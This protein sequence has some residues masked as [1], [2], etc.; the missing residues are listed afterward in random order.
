M[1]VVKK[2]KLKIYGEI[3]SEVER[4]SARCDESDDIL[5]RKWI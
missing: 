5:D 1:D 3:R 2:F 4:E